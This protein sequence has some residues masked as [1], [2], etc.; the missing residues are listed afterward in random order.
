[1]AMN[2]SVLEASLRRL[3]PETARAIINRIDDQAITEWRSLKP[4]STALRGAFNWKNSN[5]G[6]QYWIEI[7]NA[8]EADEKQLE[9]EFMEAMNG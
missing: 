9:F 7:F 5:E 1:M 3:Y 4:A 6:G 2:D 8:L